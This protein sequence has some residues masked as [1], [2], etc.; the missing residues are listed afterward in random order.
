MP[1]LRGNPTRG[2]LDRRLSCHRLHSLIGSPLRCLGKRLGAWNL[3]LCYVD[4]SPGLLRDVFLDGGTLSAGW[5]DELCG[6]ECFSRRSCA[7][8]G[9]VRA[10]CDLGQL[11]RVE[12]NWSRPGRG[13]IRSIDS[14]EL[15]GLNSFEQREGLS[16]LAAAIRQQPAQFAV[17]RFNAYE[18]FQFHRELGVP[19]LFKDLVT[20]RARER[21]QLQPTST[22]FE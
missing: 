9:R 21:L 18:F 6:G 1:P 16:C 3:H 7:L 5:S 14:Y 12:S 20:T 17:F 19:D 2:G 13:T 10:V 4:A 22:L 11:G 15:Q 8:S